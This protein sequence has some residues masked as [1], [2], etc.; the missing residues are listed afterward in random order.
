MKKLRNIF[1]MAVAAFALA[2]PAYALDTGDWAK[3]EVFKKHLQTEGHGIAAMYNQLTIVYDKDNHSDA[4]ATY[5]RNL[6]TFDNE[7]DWYLVFG[8]TP[9]NDSKVDYLKVELKGTNINF[10]KPDYKS[11]ELP[12]VVNEDIPA[13]RQ[14]AE[15]KQVAPRS[16]MLAAILKNDDDYLAFTA[17]VRNNKD[18]IVGFVDGVVGQVDASREAIDLYFTDL[19]G[20]CQN[21]KTG[22]LYQPNPQLLANA[23]SVADHNKTGN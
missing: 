18:E 23:K 14:L 3:P 11:T 5:Y 17:E 15:S 2:A 9:L 1:A 13:T 12:N 8:N 4:K 7:G 21:I 16:M 6:I 10:F 20:A 19:N 22:I